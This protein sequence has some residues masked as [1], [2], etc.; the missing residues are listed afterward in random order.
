MTLGEL[1]ATE[2]VET[3][4]VIHTTTTADGYRAIS[5]DLNADWAADCALLAIILA[6]IIAVPFGVRKK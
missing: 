1:K 4:A 5:L 3:I 2:K 6:V